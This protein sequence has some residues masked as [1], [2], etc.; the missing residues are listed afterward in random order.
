MEEGFEDKESFFF[1]FL[2]REEK[3]G[4]RHVL[5]RC[6]AL[7][8]N[9]KEAKESV[10]RLTT[11]PSPLS[12]LPSPPSPVDFPQ[13]PIALSNHPPQPSLHLFARPPRSPALALMTSS[14]PSMDALLAQHNSRIARAYEAEQPEEGKELTVR[15]SL[16]HARVDGS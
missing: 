6:P 12:L 3:Q 14:R 2:R 11:V 5:S 16:L 7:S 9:V 8:R 13:V 15:L 10:H 4:R 1:A